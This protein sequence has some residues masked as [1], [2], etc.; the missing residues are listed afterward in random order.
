M[1][2]IAW[3]LFSACAVLLASCSRGPS[4]PRLTS[5]DSAAIILE[6]IEHRGEVDRFFR[7]DPNSPFKR[8]S[9]IS[10][11]GIRWFPVNVAACWP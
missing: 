7:D 4:L 2:H 8:D 6:N 9:S 10:F 3:C 11:H 1:R 5:A